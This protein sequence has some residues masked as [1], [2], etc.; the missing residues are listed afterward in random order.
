MGWTPKRA[1]GLLYGIAGY[2]AVAGFGYWAV[3]KRVDAAAA[4]RYDK[5]QESVQN[6]NQK[7]SELA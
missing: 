2:A 6:K 1:F 3:R 5:Q 4:D 7:S